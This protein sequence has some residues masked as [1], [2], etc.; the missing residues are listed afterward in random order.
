MTVLVTGAT[1]TTGSAVVAE[2]VAHGIPV[3]AASRSPEK[4]PGLA[5][6]GVEPVVLDRADEASLRTA[7]QGVAAAYLVTQTSPDMATTEG[8][9]ARAAAE[10]GVPIVKLSTLGAAPDS[11]LRFAR[12][13]AA[14]EAALESAGGA[15][16][17]VAPNGF[18]QNDLAWAA[19]VGSG[20]VAGPVMDAAW[21]IVDAR[22]VAAVA[23]AVLADPAPYA[24]RRLAVTGP[25]ARTPRDRV[26]ALAEVL[27]RELDAVDLPFAVVA[28]HLR[29]LGVPQWQVDGIGE[30]CAL[31]AAG[32]ATAVAPDAAEVLGR[33]TRSWEEFA[34]DH[35]GVFTG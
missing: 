12:A 4:L 9:F 6:P 16:T 8:A 5:R 31:Y 17:V 11:P 29:G 35:A 34:T 33:P 32:L 24:G 28:Q 23:A 1:G 21:A 27:G 2:L 30:L 22:D 19:Q 20:A 14:A 25:A 15:W 7:L 18:M 13:H 10:A 26:R 3:R